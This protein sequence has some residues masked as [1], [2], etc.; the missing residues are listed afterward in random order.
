MDSIAVYRLSVR[1]AANH[2]GQCQCCT[3]VRRI[4]GDISPL[5]GAHIR[6]PFADDTKPRTHH[7]N[8]LWPGGARVSNDS[9]LASWANFSGLWVEITLGPASH[10]HYSGALGGEL[11]LHSP[12]G[13]CEWP[14]LSAAL[15]RDSADA[16]R[17]AD[18]ALTAG[19]GWE[20]RYRINGADDPP[21]WLHE[22]AMPDEHATGRYQL[23]IRDIT[24]DVALAQQQ[25]AEIEALRAESRGKSEFFASMNHELRTPMNGVMGMAQVMAKTRLDAEQRQYVNTI[26]ESSKAL[27]NIVNDILDFSKIEAGKLELAPEPIDLEKV[28]YDACQLLAARAAEKNLPLLLDY[29]ESYP[30]HLIADGGRLRQ[31]FLNLLGNAVKFTQHGHVILRVLF[32]GFEGDQANLRVEISDTGPG[33]SPTTQQRLFSAYAQA[34]AS[35][36]KHFGGTGLGLQISK[37]LV[38]LMGGAI[39]VDSEEGRG[40]TFWFR[41]RLPIDTASQPVAV[42]DFRGRRAVVVDPNQTSAK[43]LARYLR[44]IGADVVVMH[45]PEE[46]LAHLSSS[47]MHYDCAIIEK[48]TGAIDGIKLTRLLKSSDKHAAMPVVLLTSVLEPANGRALAKA[49]INAYLTKPVACNLLYKAVS[50]IIERGGAL[51]DGVIFIANDDLRPQNVTDGTM[52]IHGRVL[53]ADDVDINR[54]VLQAMLAEYGLSIDTAVN[55]HDAVEKW[56]NDKYDLILMDCQMPELDGYGAARAIRADAGESQRVPI[57]ALTGN[58]GETDREKCLA[59]GMDDYL[60]KPVIETALVEKITKWLG[61]EKRSTGVDVQVVNYADNTDEV[62]DREKFE[63]L[64]AMMRDKF[65]DFAGSLGDKMQE[66]YKLIRTAVQEGRVTDAGE[67]AHSLKGMAGMVGAQVVSDYASQIESSAKNDDYAAMTLALAKLEPAITRTAQAVYEQLHV[68]LDQQVV[69]F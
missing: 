19:Q 41:V 45:D 46:V 4:T 65:P 66:R 23:I 12:S 34:D 58:A 47:N 7:G 50:K 55:G 17:R 15:Y 33:M 8:R 2:L 1:V 24:A 31:I 6:F 26:I 21:R 10:V 60:T 27:L 61:V 37:R 20:Q 51:D 49:G 68:E 3:V 57:I 16:A 25:Q 52:R 44:D 39:G 59:A 22:V 38:E 48:A 18:A 35:T 40:S 54:A 29:R 62:L 5:A 42:F 67:T 9:A 13:T 14:A 43:I 32:E 69:L 63:N 64:R 56:R 36:A 53:V 28:A 11:G 30:R